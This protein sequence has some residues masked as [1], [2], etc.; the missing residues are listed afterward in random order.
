MS[1]RQD[2]LFELGTEELPPTSLHA[3]ADSLLEQITSGLKEAGLDFK[4]AQVY[5]TPRRLALVITDLLAQQ[6]P[7]HF[8]RRGPSV[9]AA[10]DASGNPTQA[11][12]GF[13]SSCGCS[14]EQL[15]QVDSAK[16]AY[17]VFSETREGEHTPTLLPPLLTQ[18]LHQLP[19]EK[20][21]RWGA[22]RYEFVR[23]VA[24]LVCLWGSEV[25]P[26]S[27]YGLQ[28][29]R[30]TRGHRVHA[31]SPLPI[32]QPQ[33]YASVL[34]TQ[35]KVEP[36][37]S[38][39]QSLIEHQIETLAQKHQF[40]VV[41]DPDLLREVT[42]LTEWPVA[43]CGSFDSSFLEVPQEALISSMQ[44]H[45]KYFPVRHQ[46]GSL[47]NRFVFIA[48]LDS[49]SPQSVIH[50]NE[51]V[52]RPRLADAMFFW[53]QDCN[54]PLVD[55]VPQLD[56]VVFHEALGTLGEKTQR[57]VR[58]SQ[59][60]AQHI[61]ANT[62]YAARGALLAKADL[63][64]DLVFEFTELQGI[65][66]SYYAKVA[67]EPDAVAAIVKEHYQ[68]RFSGDTLPTSL[69]ATAVAIADR[70]DTLMGI[71]ALGEKPTGTRDPYALR[72]ASVGILR[73][74]IEN[75]LPYD[76]RDLLTL[77]LDGYGTLKLPER[78][79]A[80]A[81]AL[82]YILE[83][84]RA[85]YLDQGY[86]IDVFLAVRALSLTAPLAIHE[87]LLALQSFKR[88]HSEVAATLAESNKRVANILNKVGAETASDDTHLSALTEPQELVLWALIQ[89]LQLE[90][91]QQVEQQQFAQALDALATLKDPLSDFFDHVMVMTDDERLRQQR[92]SLLRQTR[93]L[94]L[95]VV[96]FSLIQLDTSLND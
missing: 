20:R 17:L 60:L 70:L 43:L 45:Q 15:T 18:A 76:L 27:A 13:A 8:E 59:T 40:S 94:F 30:H 24:W 52:I 95:Q 58:L 75:N 67:G 7:Q 51:T 73:L 93:G 55:R 79:S 62:E 53:Q 74:I 32:E 28:A 42:A 83:R 48:N 19:I 26:F 72:R 25:L 38:V 36:S 37:L 88:E 57:L 69:E 16:G 29:Q 86:D 34:R 49:Q 11:A 65:A 77:A 85:W 33:Q 91:T 22:H 39:R 89:Q 78:D 92:L 82:T 6:T 5:A 64:S 23:P 44:G 10:F 68:P 54:T 31:P 96:D 84:L 56:Q 12:L 14:V 50:G 80:V 4:D 71:F 21:M 81:E 90:I 3:L 35:G 9:K 47:L 46:D 1:E 61:G 41:V 66:G 63:A 2:F 87:R